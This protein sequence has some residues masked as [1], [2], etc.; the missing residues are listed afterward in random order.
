VALSRDSLGSVGFDLIKGGAMQSRMRFLFSTMMLAL[1]FVAAVPLYRVLSRRPDIW[2]TPR[3]MLVPLGEATDRVEIYA[4]GQPLTA[5]LQNGQAR[6]AEG[7][8][9]R[10]LTPGDIGLRFNNWDRVRA[11]RLPVLLASAAGCGVTVLM[12]LLIMTGRLAWRGERGEVD[13]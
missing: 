6:V 9:M 2:W 8:S 13:A 1:F 7:G 4:L 11:D 10:V 12:L 5:L 3:T